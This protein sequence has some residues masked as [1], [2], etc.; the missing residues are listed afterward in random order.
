MRQ[1]LSLV[2]KNRRIVYPVVGL[3]VLLAAGGFAAA[4]G[5][6]SSTPTSTATDT[7][8]TASGSAMAD[9]GGFPAAGGAN[10]IVQVIN[11]QDSSYKARGKDQVNQ[12]PGPNVGPKNEALAFSS[13]VHCN[14]LAMALQI[15]LVGLGARNFQPFNQAV[16]VNYQC[17]GCVTCAIAIQKVV[18]VSDPSAIP[19]D[20]RRVAQ[21]IHDEVADLRASLVNSGYTYDCPG[22]EQ[23]ANAVVLAQINSLIGPVDFKQDMET[24]PT[25]PGASP[26]A[27]ESPSS[28]GSPSPT[29]SGA[30]TA[31][32]SP[33]PSATTSP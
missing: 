19:N 33:Q 11:H 31:S 10:N 12:I 18:Q 9:A 26:M 24:A 17:T 8:Q 28:S 21:Q 4:T 14:T 20:V 3:V 27:S 23:W 7:Q 6:F 16:A 13:C 1:W 5:T 15:D 32:A 30:P 22:L 2:A 25:T 29:V